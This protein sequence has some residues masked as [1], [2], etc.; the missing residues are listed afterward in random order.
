[1]IAL[2]NRA[3]TGKGSRVDV[4]MNDAMF[5]SLE[6]FYVTYSLT[7]KVEGTNVI[8]DQEADPYG[9]FPAKD[10]YFVLAGGSHAQF[11]TLAKLIG[12][13]ELIDDPEVNDFEKRRQHHREPGGWHELVTNWTRSMTKEEIFAVLEDA[14]IPYGRINSVKEA[15]E[16]PQL[17]ARNMIWEVYDP[18]FERNFKMSGTPLKFD[19]EEDAPVK[20]A[21]LIGEDTEEILKDLAGYTDEEIAALRAE[22]AIN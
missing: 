6:N 7:G 1:M 2:Y 15:A 17:K 10:G 4:A 22:G 5:A 8:P 21:P 19:R 20:A 18:G 9:V 11:L 14:D 13:P 12:H 16:S 3:M